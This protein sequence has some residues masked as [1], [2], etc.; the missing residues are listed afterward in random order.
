ML[1]IT[2]MDLRGPGHQQLARSFAEANTM[3]NRQLARTPR[4]LP[5]R[6]RVRVALNHDLPVIHDLLDLSASPDGKPIDLQRTLMAHLQNRAGT[7][8]TVRCLSMLH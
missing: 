3:L 7:D 1:M 5:A 6:I 4:N 2:L 8:L